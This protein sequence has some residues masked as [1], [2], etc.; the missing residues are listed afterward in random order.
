MLSLTPRS[1]IFEVRPILLLLLCFP[2]LQTMYHCRCYE[3][4]EDPIDSLKELRVSI[5]FHSLGLEILLID[6][7]N[8]LLC[9]KLICVLLTYLPLSVGYPVV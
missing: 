6:Y 7:L 4:D 3:A 9:P 5:P 1:F 2:Q 8:N